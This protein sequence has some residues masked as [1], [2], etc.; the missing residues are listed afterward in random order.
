LPGD[1]TRTD[2]GHVLPLELRQGVKRGASDVPVQP[3]R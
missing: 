2:I 1:K 3:G